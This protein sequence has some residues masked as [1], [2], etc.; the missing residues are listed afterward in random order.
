VK[1][2]TRNFFASL[3]TS[4]M[5]TDSPATRSNAAE[6]AV[7]EKACRPPPIVLTSA[8]NLTQLQKQLK[9]VAKK[10]FEFRSTKNRTRVITKDMVDFQAVKVH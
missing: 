10:I 9:G 8:T 5:D 4:N 6:E 7:P 2:A 1:V 3:R